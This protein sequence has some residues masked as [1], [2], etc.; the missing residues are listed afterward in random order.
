MSSVSPPLAIVTHVSMRGQRH[1]ESRAADRAERMM[2]TAGASGLQIGRGLVEAVQASPD[3]LR[4]LT[5]L[6]Q[7][8]QA[9]RAQAAVVELR[10][11]DARSAALI[12]WSL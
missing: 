1:A 11:A 9:Y 7:A 2:L 3:A 6:H 8:R 5:D 10:G 12:R 4:A